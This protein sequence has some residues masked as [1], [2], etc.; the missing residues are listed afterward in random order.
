VDSEASGETTTGEVA[1][2]GKKKIGSILFSRL[3]GRQTG[4][5]TVPCNV[6]QVTSLLCNGKKV[7][8]GERQCGPKHSWLGEFKAGPL[9]ITCETSR[10]LLKQMKESVEL[11]RR[12]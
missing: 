5:E 1:E 10:I 2:G 8:A 6:K 9:S 4:G 12:Y 11:T 3:R 7:S